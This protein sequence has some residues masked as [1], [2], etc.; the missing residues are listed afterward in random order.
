MGMGDRG[1]VM[2]GQAGGSTKSRRDAGVN[3]PSCSEHIHR[4]KAAQNSLWRAGLMITPALLIAGCL[5][6]LS[7]TPVIPTAPSIS[8]LQN[9][10]TCV[11]VEAIDKHLGPSAAAKAAAMKLEQVSAPPEISTIPMGTDFALWYNLVRYSFFNTVNF[12][13]FVTQSE[14]LNP[15]FNFITPLTNLGNPILKTIESSNGI[16]T[17]PSSPGATTNTNNFTLAVGFQLDGTQDRNFLL[18]Y[19]VDLRRLY[20]DAYEVISTTGEHLPSEFDP[21]HVRPRPAGIYE[22][23]NNLKTLTLP[24]GIPYGL[25]GDLAVEET[26]DSGLRALDTVMF[27]PPTPGSAPKSPQQAS[28]ATLAQSA[29]GSA[30]FS[31]KIDFT[32]L[33]GVNGG[34]NW[35]L[36]NFKGPGGGSS[37]GGGG[38]S[39]G[40]GGGSGGGGGGSGGSGGGSGGGGQLVNFN[41]S[42]QD[43]LISTFSATCAQPK[44]DIQLF[45]SDNAVVKPITA[46]QEIEL[47]TTVFSPGRGSD[48][49]TATKFTIM[50]NGSNLLNGNNL[51]KAG[52]YADPN[53]V[54]IVD[55]QVKTDARP[56]VGIGVVDGSINW[57]G[58]IE[59]FDGSSNISIRGE[60]HDALSSSFLGYI[61]LGG[62]L[63]PSKGQTKPELRVS[64]LKISQ[65]AVDLLLAQ[66]R[67]PKTNFWSSIPPCTTSGP[68]APSSLG[69]L[70]QLPG[71]V[72]SVL[73]Q[74]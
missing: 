69:I 56:P 15:S 65:S 16:T 42:K 1:L 47:S 13:L 46:N 67:P 66:V 30:A 43:T 35:T 44:P 40:G 73:L 50:L 63:T 53:G 72:G 49:S 34:P 26:L 45:S 4:Y 70:Q 9:H 7:V 10:L 55:Q 12:T 59:S 29:L 6:S 51:K 57:V 2:A 37:G 62:T 17:P 23:C 64:S 61:T 32:L 74:Q 22:Q 31:S 58:F 18:N 24:T 60:I 39:G 52:P 33:W 20:D 48:S 14:G 8:Q 36:L 38:G 27:Y 71:G 5:P 21:L 68:F 28:S 11:L 25:T 19:V 54:I 41:R 3:S